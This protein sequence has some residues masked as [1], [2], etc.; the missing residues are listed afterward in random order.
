ME[1]NKLFRL[2]NILSL[3]EEF[4]VVDLKKEMIDDAKLGDVRKFEGS[5]NYLK[6]L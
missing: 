5:G 4:P 1:I 6:A 3:L 2:L